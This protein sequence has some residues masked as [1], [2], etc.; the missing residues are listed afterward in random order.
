MKKT[1]IQVNSARN[2]FRYVMRHFWICWKKWNLFCYLNSWYLWRWFRFWTQEK[3]ILQVCADYLFRWYWRSWKRAWT[4]IFSSSDSYCQ[5]HKSSKGVF[6]PAET[7]WTIYFNNKRNNYIS[8]WAYEKW[9][10]NTTVPSLDVLWY[11][12]VYLTYLHCI[13][14]MV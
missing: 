7:F 2:V 13:G 8:W 10:T 3:Q 11:L 6:E 12:F 4:Y 5:I 9:I 14:N 1:R